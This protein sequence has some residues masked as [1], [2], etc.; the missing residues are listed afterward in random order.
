M[1]SK[2]VRSLSSLLNP[3][4]ILEFKVIDLVT[5]IFFAKGSISLTKSNM[6]LLVI[7]TMSNHEHYECV[8]RVFDL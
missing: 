5:K 6:A 1:R 3:Y 4:N 2:N 8:A 7:V